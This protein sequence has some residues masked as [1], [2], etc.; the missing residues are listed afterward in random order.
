ML[1]LQQL[2]KQISVD[3]KRDDETGLNDISLVLTSFKLLL[4]PW[5]FS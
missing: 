3:A 5:Q 2:N 1:K 4:N